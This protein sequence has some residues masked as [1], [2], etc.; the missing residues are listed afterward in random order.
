VMGQ[1]IFLEEVLGNRGP[2]RMEVWC[3]RCSF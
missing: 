3:R 1:G 2:R